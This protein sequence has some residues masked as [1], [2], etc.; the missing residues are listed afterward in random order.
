MSSSDDSFNRVRARIDA[1]ASQHGHAV[2]L[3]AVSKTKPV[4][5]IRRLAGLGQRAFGENYVQEALT[6]QGEL[7]AMALDW[8][9][10]G[11]VQSNKCR[12]VAQHFAWM[13][14]LDRTKLVA[15]L[16]SARP[17]A[18]PPLNVLIQVNIDDE[19]SKAGCAPDAIAPLADAIIREPRLRWRGLMAIPAPA[20]ANPR[21]AEPFRRM[22]TLYEQ[23]RAQH[24]I[25]TLSMGMSDD[26]ETAIAEGATMVRIG[27]AIFGART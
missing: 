22:R 4:A 27:S 18:M 15:R 9:M 24:P 7:D 26:F 16:G 1:A 13:Q 19:A 14:T 5:D 10:I 12:L 2:T 20:S 8:H 23:W 21:R 6:K 11:P 17:E 25:D 3:V